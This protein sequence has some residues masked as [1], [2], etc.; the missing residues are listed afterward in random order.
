MIW[1]V[2][3]IKKIILNGILI[4]VLVFGVV[5]CG[6]QSPSSNEK[7]TSQGENIINNE[8][9]KLY[10]DDTKL[11]FNL[12]AYT[13]VYYFE[14]DVV[15]GLEYYFEYPDSATA[16]AAVSSIK[17][18]YTAEDNIEKVIQKGNY[19]IVKFKN[20]EYQDLKVSEIKET[21]KY[22]DEFYKNN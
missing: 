9:I 13:A 15:T 1:E 17:A 12:S 10:S 5:G 21:Y 22:L 18:G 6:S 3:K 16:A 8:E 19:V 4:L 11:V 14:G 20:A 7:N 2:S